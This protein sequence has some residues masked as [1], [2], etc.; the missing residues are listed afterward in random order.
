[1]RSLRPL[2]ATSILA[3]AASLAALPSGSATADTAKPPAR[4]QIQTKKV[5][6]DAA[7]RSAAA[8]VVSA[9]APQLFLSRYD[10]VKAASTLRSGPLRFVPYTRTYKGLPVDGGDFVVVVDKGGNVVYTSVAQTGKV[11]LTD[12]SPSITSSAARSTSAG[13]VDRAQLSRST[14]V[15]LQRGSRSSLAWKTTATG[16][17]KGAPSRLDVYVDATSGK[18]LQTLENVADGEG[19]AAY[20]GPDP[21]TIGTTHPGAVYSMT[22]PGTPSLVC[23][24][25]A[26]NVT[27]TGPDDVWGNGVATN[28]ET[29]C[30]D[31]LYAAQQQKL[32]LKGWLGRDGMNG[33]GGWLPIRVG[34]NDLNAFYDGYEIQIGHNN[35]NQ[36]ISSLDVVAHEFGHGIDDFTPGGISRNGTQ[37]FVGDTFGAS[38]EYYDNQPAPYDQRDFLVGEEINLVGSGPIRNM[39][40]PSLVNGDPNCY[41]ASVDNMEVHA[42]AGPGNHWFYLAAIGS[43]AAGQPVSPR[44]A[45]APAVTGIGVSKTMKIMYTA[46]LMKTTASSY[47]QYRAWTLTAARHLYGQSSCTEF[48]RVKAAWNAVSVPALAGEATCTVGQA[49]VSIT[50]ATSRTFNANTTIAPFTMTASGGSSPYSWSATGL[51]TGLSISPTTGQISG[52]LGLASGGSYVVQVTAT[53]T[54]ARVGTAWFTLKVN[55]PTTASCTGQ[56][57][58]NPGFE[59]A[60]PVPWVMSAGS[61]YADGSQH[62]GTK[63]AWMGGWGD[64]VTEVA[65]QQVKIP[66]GCKATLTFWVKISTEESGST[67]FDKYTVKANNFTLKSLSN[68]NANNTWTL[69]TAIVPAAFA[70]ANVTFSFTS[71]EDSSL[72]T[73]FRLDDVA[74]TISTP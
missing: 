58:G 43:N 40:N 53:D 11:R 15:V 12:V 73:S 16:L 25:S 29:G 33:A 38:T 48:N 55:S 67:A 52:T 35:A 66:A 72:A 22:T 36:W 71:D 3:V 37:E 39:Y 61:I 4:H 69:Q 18:V 9:K 51:P 28:K 49:S 24:D 6:R 8:A 10:K 31:A 21:V 57:L 54:A 64:D 20:S 7:A 19:H 32:M 65:S 70:G 14:L 50:N 63:Y 59:N 5:D 34:L 68:V 13:K 44:C 41:S 30:V 23:Q 46:M 26:T 47:K 60:I 27:F 42:A 56:R 45:G 2:V 62:G 74:L 1:M 17:R